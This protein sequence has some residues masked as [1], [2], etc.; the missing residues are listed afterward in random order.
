M[1]EGLGQGHQEKYYETV[2]Q[3]FLGDESFVSQVAERSEAKE[4]ELRG[5]KVGFTRLLHAVS[6][7]R[8]VESGL[9]SRAGRQR[10]W[11]GVRAQ[12]VYLA[13]NGVG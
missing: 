9:L 10:R 8:G 7:A 6:Q 5:K 1:E 4:V 12:L 11:V 13:G 3:R 2:D